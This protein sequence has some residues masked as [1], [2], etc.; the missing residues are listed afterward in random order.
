MGEGA[1]ASLGLLSLLLAPG[2]EFL[3]ARLLF[4]A[5]PCGVV[6]GGLP[7]GCQFFRGHPVARP[8]G[9]VGCQVDLPPLRLKGWLLYFVEAFKIILDEAFYSSQAI[10][11]ARE[12]II[13][14]TGLHAQGWHALASRNQLG[15]IL[16]RERVG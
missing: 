4:I 9:H 7:Q 8:A 3:E 5:R 13:R 14:E 6:G 1:A 10:A 11:A 16:M 15:V 2:Q 12:I